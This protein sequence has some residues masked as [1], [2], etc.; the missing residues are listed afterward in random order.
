MNL[1]SVTHKKI[2]IPNTKKV[3]SGDRVTR[4]SLVAPNIDFLLSIAKS[5][6]G[7]FLYV[8]QHDNDT[9][10]KIALVTTITNENFFVDSSH[11]FFVIASEDHFKKLGYKSVLEASYVDW[12]TVK[13]TTKKRKSRTGFRTK[14]NMNKKK[15]DENDHVNEDDT[16]T[17]SKGV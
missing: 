9:N 15:K 8:L 1:G 5:D 2:T 16:T 6:S 12:V 10:H 3:S 7:I 13:E 14:R 17:L 4:R 11:E